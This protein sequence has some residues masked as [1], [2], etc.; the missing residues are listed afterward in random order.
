MKILEFHTR[1]KKTMKLKKNLEKTIKII[2]SIISRE[3]SESHE[4]LKI[5]HKNHEM[6]IM[7]ICKFQ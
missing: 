4:Y 1:I 6:K 3:N 7:K 5:P 2:D